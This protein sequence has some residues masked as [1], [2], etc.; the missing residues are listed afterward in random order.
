MMTK[1]IISIIMIIILNSVAIPAVWADTNYD[2][3]APVIN[4]MVIHNS[5][6]IDANDTLDITF[7]ITE[8]GSGVNMI[9]ITFINIETNQYAYLKYQAANSGSNGLLFSGNYDIS[10]NISAQSTYLMKGDYEV[11][12]VVIY[13][14]NGN[15][16]SYNV[17][18]DQIVPA[19]KTIS[20]KR[21]N[22]KDTEAPIIESVTIKNAQNMEY[23]KYFNGTIKLTEESALSFL[24]LTYKNNSNEKLTV[25]GKVTG[26]ITSGTYNMDFCIAGSGTVS[27]GDYYLASI[28]AYDSLGNMYYQDSE[29]WDDKL[30]TNKVTLI[31]LPTDNKEGISIYSLEVEEYSVT[32]PNVLT[33]HINWNPGSEGIRAMSVSITNENGNKK[34]LYWEPDAPVTSKEITIKLPLNTY[35]ENGTYHI[36]YVMIYSS[37]FK[38]KYADLL[39]ESIMVDNHDIEIKSQY[40]IAYYGSTA[41]ISGVSK[42][43]KNMNNGE[44]S[45]A[46]YSVQNIADQ[47]IFQALAGRN[48]TLVF[49]GPDVQWVFYGKDIDIKKCKSIDLSV[50]IKVVNGKKYGYA[51]DE[52]V[53]AI[54]FAN[55]GELPGKA[56]IRISSEYLKA[57]Y[58]YKSSMVLSYYDNTP[59]V[60]DKNIDCA[61]DGYAEI[62]ITHNS[63]YIL[64]DNA[65]RLAAPGNF[66]VK[67]SNSNKVTLSWSQ[68]Y[69]ALGYKIYRAQGATGSYKLIR[70][71]AGGST[72]KFVDTT[73]K[74]GR[75]YYYR[76][77]AYGKNVAAIYSGKKFVKVLPGKAKISVKSK[78]SKKV[79]LSVKTADGI[80]NFEIYVS[81]KGKKYKKIKTVKNKKKVT[82]NK[83]YKN[84]YIKVRAYVKYKGK[85]IY[86]KYS[87]VKKL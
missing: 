26:N 18:N 73:I 11:S 60:L 57:K 8:E 39:L 66:T 63:T 9:G 25:K 30:F 3:T 68:V 6:E 87:S 67:S 52:K 20:V 55:N 78:S 64:S 38:A 62:E 49:E 71:V 77:C 37:N 81:K 28:E 34:A 17:Q 41:N 74:A 12:N 23:N 69:G 31:S 54:E 84:Y 27:K 32:T 61:N 40:D 70:T 47:Q 48:A 82:I 14:A 2:V 22:V 36:D 7:N 21:S 50:N 79:K 72:T 76:I 83:K 33:F 85:K 42:A 13:D 19:T 5:A 1:K 16:K 44:V 86:G 4:S 65:P 51:D 80:S 53:L 24:E 45:I 59:E 29:Q 10:L 43:I 58:G 15:K 56:T 35:L 46:E 75:E